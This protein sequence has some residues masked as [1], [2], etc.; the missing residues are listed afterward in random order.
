MARKMLLGTAENQCTPKA[1]PRRS[2]NAAG[3]SCCLLCPLAGV[4]RSA[5]TLGTMTRPAPTGPAVVGA[6]RRWRGRRRGRRGWRAG[7]VAGGGGG[8]AA[9]AAGRRERWRGCAGWRGR[10]RGRCG[11]RRARRRG[12]RRRRSGWRKWRRERQCRSRRGNCGRE[13]GCVPSSAGRA[14]CGGR[15]RGAGRSHGHQHRAHDGDRRS[16]APAQEPR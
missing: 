11:G 2:S 9:G 10:W 14:G 12:R 7:G 16:R 4:T 6:A 13:R 8:G 5:K 15:L 1:V 3:W